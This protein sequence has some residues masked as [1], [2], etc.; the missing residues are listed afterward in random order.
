MG[1][2]GFAIAGIISVIAWA[3]I[4]RRLRVA[5]D[6]LCV[7]PAGSCGSSIDVCAATIHAIVDLFAYLFGPPILFAVLGD[8]LFSRRRPA[9]VIVAYLACAVAGPWLVTFAGARILHA[10]RDRVSTC[11]SGTASTR[12]QC[13]GMPAKKIPIP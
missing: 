4:D 9:H 7:P 3:A 1:T 2:I 5:F 8:G 11:P 13:N 6:R 12:C 10:G